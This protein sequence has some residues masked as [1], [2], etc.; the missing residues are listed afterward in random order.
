MF[1]LAREVNPAIVTATTH[2]ARWQAGLADDISLGEAVP[3]RIS[4]A[5]WVGV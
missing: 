1:L 5:S 4:K 3:Y 2:L